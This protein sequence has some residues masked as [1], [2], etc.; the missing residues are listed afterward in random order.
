MRSKQGGIKAGFRIANTPRRHED[1]YV[2]IIV[3]KQ[4]YTLC[5]YC[6][7]V[8]VKQLVE[9][10]KNHH[11]A[12]GGQQIRKHAGY[13]RNLVPIADGYINVLRQGILVNDFGKL[14]QFNDYW[15]RSCMVACVL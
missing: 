3:S 2:R 14:A 12:A 6:T 7:L 8:R 11:Y 10:V 1:L 13:R 15:S 4:F 5:Y 9:T